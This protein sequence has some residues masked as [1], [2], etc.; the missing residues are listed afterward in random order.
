[1]L[2]FFSALLAVIRA[3]PI[4]K[5]WVDDFVAF[6]VDRQIAQMKRENLAAIRRVLMEQDQRDL[7][8]VIGSPRAGEVSGDPNT[9]IR[10]SLPNVSPGTG[11]T[12]KP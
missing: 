3:L 2:S 6:Y 12:A 4:I 8:K 1:M 5:G 10:D 11:G 9:Q 7:E